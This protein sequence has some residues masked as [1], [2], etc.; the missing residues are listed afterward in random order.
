MIYSSLGGKIQSNPLVD[1]LLFK[2]TA[3]R[4]RRGASGNA[5]S[6]DQFLYDPSKHRRSRKIDRTQPLVA[7]VQSKWWP[8]QGRWTL[9][10]LRLIHTAPKN[11]CWQNQLFC[12]AKLG[13]AR[14]KNVWTR[15]WAAVR[16]LYRWNLKPKQTPARLPIK[17]NFRETETRKTWKYWQVCVFNSCHTRLYLRYWML[18]NKV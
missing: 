12:W 18:G 14:V 7:A 3:E 2:W 5:P 16:W 1:Q 9:A 8:H 11:P 13:K 10:F 15:L 6:L 4:K 17:T